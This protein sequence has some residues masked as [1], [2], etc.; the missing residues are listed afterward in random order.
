M[1]W[2]SLLTARPGY[3]IRSHNRWLSNWVAYR[4]R[5]SRDLA[6]FRI[7]RIASKR[8]VFEVENERD[9]AGRDRQKLRT[10]LV[11]ALFAALMIS[12]MIFVMTF[13]MTPESANLGQTDEPIKHP[14]CVDLQAV[15]SF[16][17]SKSGE[18]FEVQGWRFDT[19]SQVVILGQLASADYLATCGAQTVDMRV[20]FI[21]QGEAWQIEKMAPTK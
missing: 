8:V 4:A 7:I 18:S 2:R 5:A 1:N 12:I 10:V 17:T 14:T 15:R 20:L 13:A 11:P 16:E 21:R 19:Q 9:N 6:S 3:A